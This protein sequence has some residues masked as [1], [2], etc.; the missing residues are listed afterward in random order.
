MEE[1]NTNEA[2]NELN[3]SS[4]DFLSFNLDNLKLSEDQNQEKKI[5]TPKPRE[6]NRHLFKR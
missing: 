2:Q 5:D 1:K 3:L 4:E 6:K